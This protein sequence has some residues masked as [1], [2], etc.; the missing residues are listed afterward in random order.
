M[1]SSTAPHFPILSGDGARAG[2]QGLVMTPASTG[3]LWQALSQSFAQFF[4][5]PRPLPEQGESAMDSPSL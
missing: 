5:A 4:P 2:P 1:N 3:P